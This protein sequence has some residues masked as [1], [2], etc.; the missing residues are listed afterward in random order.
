MESQLL[1]RL[2]L[3]LT[4]VMGAGLLHAGEPAAP[5][6]KARI[7]RIDVRTGAGYLPLSGSATELPVEIGLSAIEGCRLALAFRSEGRG[8]LFD[9]N[10]ALEFQLRDDDGRVLTLDGGTRLPIRAGAGAAKTVATIVL[11]PGQP[12]Q[13]GRYGDRLVVQVLDDE[14]VVVERDLALTLRVQ[15]QASVSLAGSAASGFSKTFGAGLDFGE[16][17]E[18]KEREALLF[19]VANAAYA[20]RLGSANRGKLRHTTYVDTVGYLALLDGRALD[21]SADVLVDGRPGGH[22]L[23]WTPYRLNV[24]IGDITGRAAGL[25]RDVITVDVILLE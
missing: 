2:L 8:R 11:A 24:R 19:V 1:I 15:S 20:L 12:V 5:A 10:D 16:L 18:G 7:D 6:C 21:L 22:W 3:V 23:T 25:Y 4:V 9:G 13:A 17:S 14:Q